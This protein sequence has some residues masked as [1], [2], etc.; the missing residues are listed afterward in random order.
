MKSVMVVQFPVIDDKS[1]QYAQMSKGIAKENDTE[2]WR[3]SELGYELQRLI[4]TLWL[5][6]NVWTYLI[7]KKPNMRNTLK[8]I[9]QIKLIQNHYKINSTLA[10]NTNCFLSDGKM[11]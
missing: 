8:H 9:N 3:F 2:Y 6:L 5:H 11:M 4:K 7:N 10:T 1:D